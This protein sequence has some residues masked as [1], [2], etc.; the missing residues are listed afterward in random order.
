MVRRPVPA[1][2]GELVRRLHGAR[3]RCAAMRNHL[4]AAAVGGLD[5]VR[6]VPARARPPAVHGAPA[7]HT[8]ARAPRT[9]PARIPGG[10][11]QRPLPCATP[12]WPYCVPATPAIAAG[13]GMRRGTVRCDTT[14][15]RWPRYR[16]KG[17]WPPRHRSAQGHACQRLPS[18]QAGSLRS[19]RW[20]PIVNISAPSCPS[21]AG[22]LRF[23][24]RARPGACRR[25][26]RQ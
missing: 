18:P 23:H 12:L 20:R 21:G 1:G 15:T 8:H 22:A 19:R 6:V 4:A 25:R 3:H 9:A 10:H 16:G 11:A 13:R 24:S 2:H 7:C 26:C 5:G 17:R 14:G